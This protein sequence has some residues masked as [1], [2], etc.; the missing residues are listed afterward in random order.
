MHLADLLAAPPVGGN[1]LVGSRVAVKLHR[2][3]WRSPLDFRSAAPEVTGIDRET[4]RHKVRN[5][6]VLPVDLYDAKLR[7][8]TASIRLVNRWSPVIRRHA[9]SLYLAAAPSSSTPQ[10]SPRQSKILACTTTTSI[11]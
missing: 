2:H 4:S 9:R 10:T 5:V 8:Q 1:R 6:G 3:G 11:N 7:S